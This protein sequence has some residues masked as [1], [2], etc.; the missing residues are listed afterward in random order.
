MA[1]GGGYGAVVVA[2]DVVALFQ[3]GLVML[4]GQA[5]GEETHNGGIAHI[6]V[7]VR[8][9]EHTNA[10]IV[11]GAEAIGEVVLRSDA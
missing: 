10:P 2:H 5:V 4:V 3:R 6:G 9:L 11:V 1:N 7:V 8:L